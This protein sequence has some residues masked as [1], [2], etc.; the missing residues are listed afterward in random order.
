VQV[1][2]LDDV[3]LAEPR[4]AG[5]AERGR[6]EGVL[7]VEAVE[8]GSRSA[9]DCPPGVVPLDP[10]DRRVVGDLAPDEHPG[11]VPTGIQPAVDLVRRARRAARGVG[12][13]DM[14]DV[15]RHAAFFSGVVRERRRIRG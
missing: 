1:V 12:F 15:E 3:G 14:Q 10:P 5:D 7:E 9:V 4:V 2:E 13:A 6:I 8:D 11:G